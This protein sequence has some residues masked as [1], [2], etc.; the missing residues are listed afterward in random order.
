MNLLIHPLTEITVDTS[1][2]ICISFGD[3][4]IQFSPFGGTWSGTGIG[5][6]NG[7]FSP[8]SAGIGTHKLLYS[9]HQ[10]ITDSWN[11]DSLEI[12][13]KTLPNINYT[14]DSI[15]CIDQ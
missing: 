1:F 7:L 9:N 10:P 4:N 11:N 12:T 2:E 3:T 5:I 14:H 8:L 13:E 15:I 6:N